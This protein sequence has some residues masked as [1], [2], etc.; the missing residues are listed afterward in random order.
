VRTTDVTNNNH[1][2]R[3]SNTSERVLT[4][5]LRL[6]TI[7]ADKLHQDITGRCANWAAVSQLQ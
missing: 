3:F 1:V 4:T 5:K 2:R 6:V 7:K